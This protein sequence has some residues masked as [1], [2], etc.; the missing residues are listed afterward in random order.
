MALKHLAGD[1]PSRFKAFETKFSKVVM[2]G[3][4]L[5]VRGYKLEQPGQAAVTVTVK[6][7]GEEAIANGLFEYAV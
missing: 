1:D 6:E 4:T 5:I 2:P 3:S 7:T